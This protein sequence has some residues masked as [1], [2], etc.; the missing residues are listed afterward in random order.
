MLGFVQR[1]VFDDFRYGL[2]I[3]YHMFKCLWKNEAIWGVRR[4][5]L[6]WFQDSS[7]GA[8]YLGICECLWSVSGLKLVCYSL[9]S[10]WEGAVNGPLRFAAAGVKRATYRAKS[11]FA[12]G[13]KYMLPRGS[14]RDLGWMMVR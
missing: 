13:L 14:I 2:S 9:L 10:G 8:D 11:D 3:C 12:V 5:R 7:R 1:H 4:S 6:P